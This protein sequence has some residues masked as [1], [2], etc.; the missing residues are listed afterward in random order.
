MKASASQTV[1]L[2]ASTPAASTR[3]PK[4]GTG[5]LAVLALFALLAMGANYKGDSYRG[6]SDSN[7]GNGVKSHMQG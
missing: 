1:S 7:L 5:L 2:F 4:L 6:D 3:G